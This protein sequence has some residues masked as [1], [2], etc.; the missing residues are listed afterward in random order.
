MFL[1]LRA[2]RAAVSIEDAAHLLKLPLK[3]AA[4]NCAA[5]VRHAAMKT[6]ASSLSRGLADSFIA[7]MRK[8]AVII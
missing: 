7:S 8:S 4:I 2:I 5:T 3:K 6:N 1:D